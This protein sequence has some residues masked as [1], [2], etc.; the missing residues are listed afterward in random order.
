MFRE[1]IFK[2]LAFIALWVSAQS[3]MFSTLLSQSVSKHVKYHRPDPATITNFDEFGALPQM[4]NVYAAI[5]NARKVIVLRVA[6]GTLVSYDDFD[7]SRKNKLQFP[8]G[9]QIVNMLINPR[10]FLVVTGVIGDCRLVVKIARQ[11]VLNHTIEYDIVPSGEYL[12][13]E[14]SSYIQKMT[15]ESGSRP[16][17]CHAFVINTAPNGTIHEISASGAFSSVFAG[18]AGG[19]KMDESNAQLV[20]LY[21]SYLKKNSNNEI[22]L[23]DAKQISQEVLK[24]AKKEL[25]SVDKADADL[26]SSQTSVRFAFIPDSLNVAD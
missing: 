18:T 15:F 17:G 4:K 11:I 1:A 12:T 22:C 24:H 6:N 26:D 7:E 13:K 8:L 3:G 5:S 25:F 16:L 14:I 2:C 9:G 23:D 19:K 21:H 10:N 20:E